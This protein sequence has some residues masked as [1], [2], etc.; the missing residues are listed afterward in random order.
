MPLSNKR[1]RSVEKVVKHGKKKMPSFGDKL[2]DDDIHAVI[3]YV[4]QL[5]KTP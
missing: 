3:A 1:T 4:R 5:A 2:S